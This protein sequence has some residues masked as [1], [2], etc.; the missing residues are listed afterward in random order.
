[1]FPSG[2]FYL[3]L[4]V[5]D[6]RAPIRPYLFHSFFIPTADLLEVDKSANWAAMDG[7]VP[8]SSAIGPSVPFQASCGFDLD[9]LPP[10]PEMVFPG[11][12]AALIEFV[13]IVI[14]VQ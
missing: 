7:I 4:R 10:V 5:P 9:V 13:I 1:M 14:E 11:H 6:N 2:T 8:I 3:I 12:S